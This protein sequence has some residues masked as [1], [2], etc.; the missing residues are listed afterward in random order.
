MT[1]PS[2]TEL[3]NFSIRSGGKKSAA[4]ITIALIV[5]STSDPV[6]TINSI[7]K[8]TSNGSFICEFLLINTEKEGY[9]YDK[10]L[11]VFP[12]MR[13]ILPRDRIS[14]SS[15]FKIAVSESLSNN[16]LFINEHFTLKSLDFNVLRMYLS[17]TFFGILIP[18]IIDERDGVIPN[19]IKGG[20]RNSFLDTISVDIV[21]T[22]IS[23]LYSKYFCF[24][25]NR[26]AY[27]SRN[28]ELNEY[29]DLKYTLLELGYKLWKEGY[30]ITQVRNFKVEYSGVKIDDISVDFS[31]N[32]Y[33]LFNLM[34]ISDRALLK[35]RR[36]K[37][38]LLV[39]NYFI[40]FRWSR[41]SWFFK[42]LKLSGKKIN[43]ILS[44]PVEDSA[45]ISII[46]KDIK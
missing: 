28:L 19:I 7:Y 38:F 13:V 30:I 27:I 25:I 45:I 10:L 43:D 6:E 3:S 44:K 14:V 22:A 23:S 41:M 9:K 4:D 26:E 12:M 39:I 37:I 34:N 29:E 8:F 2:Y 5:N 36:I 40:T 32:D 42:K 1:L 11:A 31:S 46:N 33:L 15:A 17:E 18:L 24:L 20:F 35:A 16:L 21:G